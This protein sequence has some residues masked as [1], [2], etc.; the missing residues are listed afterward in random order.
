M[1]ALKF[2]QTG[3]LD[4]L[5]VEEVTVPIPAEGEVLVE[6][7]AAAI[8]PSDIKNVQ[9]KMHE[10]TVPR[11]PGRDFAGMIVKGPDERWVNRGSVRVAISVS[12]VTAVT[13][14]ISPSL[15]P[16][17]SLC[18]GTWVL[19]KRRGS[20][21]PISRLGLRWSMPRKSRRDRRR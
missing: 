5:H 16:R 1:R 15:P 20:A 11:I 14:S 21:S 17:C 2:Y 12:A 3:S 7:K 13:R 4:D 10:T 19:N 8:N 18:Q 6:V 9:G